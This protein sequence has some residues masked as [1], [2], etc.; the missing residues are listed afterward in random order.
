MSS[1]GEREKDILRKAERVVFEQIEHITADNDLNVQELEILDKLIDVIKD[2]KEACV[3]DGSNEGLDYSGKR[4][5]ND[6][7][8]YD[9]G[10]SQRGPYMEWGYHNDGMRFDRGM[11]G[12]MSY[13]DRNG[14]GGYR[15]GMQSG[16]YSRDDYKHRLKN[17]LQRAMEEATTDKERSAIMQ[18]MNELGW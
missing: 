16:G 2:I 17:E 5:V 18:C 6:G 4:Y 15:G 10:Y 13:A 14:M 11:N 1:Y 8:K 12:G 7:W 9:D 3:M